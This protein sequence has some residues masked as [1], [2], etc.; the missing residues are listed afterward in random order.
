MLRTL[1]LGDH[2]TKGNSLGGSLKVCGREDFHGILMQD[3][4]KLGCS[5]VAMA[6]L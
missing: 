5:R 1:G 3:S 2:G 4:K 6:Y